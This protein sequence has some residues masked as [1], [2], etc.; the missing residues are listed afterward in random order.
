MYGF[1]DVAANPD[2]FRAAVAERRAFKPLY[3]KVKLIYGCNLK[4][5]FCKHWRGAK[6]APLPMQRFREV[7]TEL[8]GLGCQKVHFSGGEPLLRPQVPELTEHATALGLRVNLTT[9]GT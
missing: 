2:E 7:V 8:A 3:V 6:E 9:N 1:E 5:E 4:C